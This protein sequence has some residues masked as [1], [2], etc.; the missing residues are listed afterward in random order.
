M[1]WF[2]LLLAVLVCSPTQARTFRAEVSHVTDGDTLWVRSARGAPRQVRLRGIDAPELCQPFGA[3]AH[4]ALAARL[5]HRPVAVTLAGKDDY[6]RWLGT[7]SDNGEDVA[8]WLVA[9]GYA[10]SHRWHRLPGPYATLEA[11]AREARRGL[12]A[13]RA[14]LDP[15]EFRK[16]HGKCAR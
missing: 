7:V 11:R 6:Q 3:E 9:G 16:L 10:W 4:R 12:W 15:R 2:A 8:A 5:L 14:P 13:Q 1:H